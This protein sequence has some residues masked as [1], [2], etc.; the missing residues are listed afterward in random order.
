M[1]L[2][3]LLKLSDGLVR[4]IGSALGISIG[5]TVIASQFRAR[6]SGI[7]GYS[8]PADSV[9]NADVTQLHGI[10]VRGPP[11]ASC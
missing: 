7:A 8:V 6:A 1:P 9:L 2:L 3:A 11:V 5:S 4:L 10:Q